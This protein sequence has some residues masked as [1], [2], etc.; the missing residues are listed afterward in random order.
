MNRIDHLELGASVV[1]NSWF[2][3]DRAFNNN[4]LKEVILKNPKTKIGKDS[5]PAKTVITKLKKA[6]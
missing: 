1:D 4:P 3:D 5:F 2:W 6:K